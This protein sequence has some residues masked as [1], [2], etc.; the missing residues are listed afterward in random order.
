M[1]KIL[2][3]DDIAETRANIKRLIELEDDLQV[4]AEAINGQD[5]IEKAKDI[6]PD[7]VLMDINMPDIDGIEATEVISREVAE[8]SIIMMSV[9]EEQDY[10]RKAMMVGAREYL[11]KPFGDDELI[12]TIKQVHE[13]ESK[14]KDYLTTEEVQLEAEHKKVV[15][16]FSS[17]GGVGKTLLATNLAVHLQQ[18]QGLDTVLVDLDLQFGDVAVM[19]DLTPRITI[20]DVVNDLQSLSP[21]NI[22][23]YLLNY[24]NGLHVLASPLR[25]EE[26]EVINGNQVQRIIDILKERFDYVIIDTAQ[27]FSDQTLTALD[28][29]NLILL[30]AMLDLPT[31]KN[32]RLCL[33]VMENLN[34]PEEKIKLVLNRS[35]KDVGIKVKDL[36]D[37]LNYSV[38]IHIPS[39]GEITVDA[40]NQGVPFVTSKPKAKISKHI[41]KLADLLVDKEEALSKEKEGLLNKITSFLNSSN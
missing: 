35:S 18:A 40:I 19:L 23:D 10:L 41:A 29:S 2:L 5:A 39:N 7:I 1:I 11:I 32:V 22:D 12:N 37:N 21:D 4:I 31:I 24:E 27:S 9:Q 26:A 28:N 14:R 36:E 30:I 34:Y 15:S 8:T 6:K 13:L 20:T 16:V 3:A 17:K 38:D 25:P 33:E